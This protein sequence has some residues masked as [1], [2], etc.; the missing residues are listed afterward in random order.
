M[1]MEVL[2]WFLGDTIQEITAKMWHF[3]GSIPDRVSYGAMVQS[4]AP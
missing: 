4:L 1:A 2:G 3:L